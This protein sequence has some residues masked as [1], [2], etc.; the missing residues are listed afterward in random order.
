M[1]L[2]VCDFF[3]TDYIDY[4]HNEMFI[5]HLKDRSLKKIPKP[6]SARILA[7]FKGFFIII[8]QEP[9]ILQKKKFK[10]GAIIA[11]LKS[12]AGHKLQKKD[13]QLIFEPKPNQSSVGYVMTLKDK[14]IFSVLEDVRSKIFFT[15]IIKGQWQVPQALDLPSRGEIKPFT[16]TDQKNLFFYTSAFFNEPPAVFEY[17][18]GKKPTRLKTSPH[19]FYAKDLV[20]K[21]KFAAS[22]DKTRI[23]YFLVYKKGIKYNSKNPTLLYGYGGFQNP[24]MPSYKPL[25]GKLFLERKGVYVLAN[26]RGGGE[27]GPKWHKA[28]LRENRQK[29]FNDFIA[30]AKDVIRN[31]IT[32]PNYLAIQGGS[33]GGLLVGVAMT[34]R[35]E[36]FKA[37]I[38]EVPLL[39]MLRYA[40]LFVGTSW[41]TEYGDPEIPKYRKVLLKYSPY[42]NVSASKQYPTAFIYTSAIDDR[43]HP[44]HARKMTAKMQ[45]QG[46][47]VLYYEHSQ[48][49]HSVSANLKQMA[50]Q[51]AMIY[52]FLWQNIFSKDNEIP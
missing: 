5:F 15:E 19:W 7:Y 38:L 3:R 50:K 16:S 43:V 25:L 40:K 46:H 22:K 30:V 26:I 35:P 20:V 8:L 52:H 29:S 31:K 11:I 21:Q 49:G 23:P 37:A 51:K 39:D 1:I 18:F 42:H 6:Q 48:G 47:K 44:G 41:V 12:T 32:S 24:M 36:L 28:A 34:Q 27:Y 2:S 10:T 17:E 14:I 33:N 9:L 45:K 4:L 13:I